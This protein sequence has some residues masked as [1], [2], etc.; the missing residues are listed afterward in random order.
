MPQCLLVLEKLCALQ[1]CVSPVSSHPPWTATLL[2]V[3]Q[4]ILEFP[5]ETKTNRAE[6]EKG[7]QCEVAMATSHVSEC[8]SSAAWLALSSVPCQ[9]AWESRGKLVR[10]LETLP[11][12]GE[13][14]RSSKLLASAGSTL[15]VAE[16]SRSLPLC[17]TLPFN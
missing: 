9:C 17:I 4:D 12:S 8:N 11:P 13:L 3:R 14:Q 15:A 1:G 10:V 2:A 5:S 16:D 7:G 6:L